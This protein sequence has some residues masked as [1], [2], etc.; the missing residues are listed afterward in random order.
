LCLPR[1]R[2][3]RLHLAYA[4]CNILLALRCWA[5]AQTRPGALPL[6]LTA[7]CKGGRKLQCVT[8]PSDCANRVCACLKPTEPF[9]SYAGRRTCSLPAQLNF[10][11]TKK[12]V[13]VHPSHRKLPLRH[14][15]NTPTKIKVFARLFQKAAGGLEGGALQPPPTNFRK[16]DGRWLG[17]QRPPTSPHRLSEGRRQAA[18]RA[19]PSNV[20]PQTFGRKTTSARGG[21]N[22]AYRPEMADSGR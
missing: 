12:W 16:E 4:K 13:A 9:P 5:P 14:P 15:P 2:V 6:D 1:K 3:Q 22:R 7:F 11:F 18:W 20:S 8:C 17:G 21:D 10:F 19:A